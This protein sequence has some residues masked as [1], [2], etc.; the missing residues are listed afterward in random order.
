MTEK[1]E[2]SSHFADPYTESNLDTLSRLLK[3][4]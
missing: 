4:R 1:S 3:D 2:F